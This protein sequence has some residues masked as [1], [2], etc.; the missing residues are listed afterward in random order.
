MIRERYHI[1]HE[2]DPETQE[3]I[4]QIRAIMD[5]MSNGLTTLRDL[6][7]KLR[8][9]NCQE[10]I[11]S[12]R[13]AIINTADEYAPSDM[14][15]PCQTPA[16]SE[17]PTQNAAHHA[18]IAKLDSDKEAFI[19][20]CK[21]IGIRTL[22]SHETQDITTTMAT[23]SSSP[24]PSCAITG[25]TTALPIR[26]Q[27]QHSKTLQ[28]TTLYCDI[29]NLL[30]WLD[31]DPQ[32]NYEGNIE[33]TLD[34]NAI[35]AIAKSQV[36]PM[37]A[38]TYQQL[39]HIQDSMTSDKPSNPIA[40]LLKTYGKDSLHALSLMMDNTN[41]RSRI[42]DLDLLTTLSHGDKRYF[43]LSEYLLANGL[44]EHYALIVDQCY[45]VHKGLD[46]AP[47]QRLSQ[48]GEIIFL[49]HKRWPMHRFLMIDPDIT[50]DYALELQAIDKLHQHAINVI[51][52]TLKPQLEKLCTQL[53][54]ER[55][56]YIRSD[57]G[58]EKKTGEEINTA[59]LLD[60][61]L[62]SDRT[63]ISP[64]PLDRESFMSGVHLNTIADAM[65]PPHHTADSQQN[66]PSRALFPRTPARTP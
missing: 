33:V 54:A 39:H 11:Q 17:T 32:N 9:I 16:R 58:F 43:S 24:L 61:C 50:I 3:K 56:Y 57:N 13:Q 20:Y 63:T 22:D 7:V 21:S 18:A 60:L 34:Y 64:S 14:T 28:T 49:M 38:A 27:L 12:Y 44:E 23:A 66:D 47:A 35:E 31:T 1:S 59:A 19:A 62:H 5:A 53:D 10:A 37:P 4:Q 42:H 36:M 25:Q 65:N 52:H 26:I 30:G 15:A 55:P 29:T 41:L 48:E 51:T 2:H 40:L 8:D 45:N 46:N 6:Q